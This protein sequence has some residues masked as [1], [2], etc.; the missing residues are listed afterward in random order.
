MSTQASKKPMP[1][2]ITAPPSTSTVRL[3]DFPRSA[4]LADQL[5][6]LEVAQAEIDRRK[7][8]QLARLRE[9]QDRD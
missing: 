6:T 8:E 1:S 5:E 3:P 9:I 7:A 2:T 4:E